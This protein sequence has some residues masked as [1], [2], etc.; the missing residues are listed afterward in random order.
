MIY[1]G[2][3]RGF[4]T[5]KY[6]PTITRKLNTKL[7]PV[8]VAVLT[9]AQLI[10][11]YRGWLV[12]LVGLALLWLISYGWTGSLMRCLTLQREMRFGWAQVGDR[13]EERFT[14]T[15][16]GLAPALWL[17]LRDQSTMP[18]YHSSRVTW[19]YGNSQNRWQT[20]IMCQHR[21]VF[22]LGPTQLQTGDPFGIY[23]L[24]LFF[25]ESKTI[26]I[27]PPIVP[28]PAI[29]I[30]PGGRTG[31][32]RP[33]ANSLDRTVSVSGLRDYVPGDDI[34]SIHWP[35]SAR[36]NALYVRLFDNL[37]AG[38]WWIFLDLAEAAQVGQG[39][40]ST[41]EH[42]VVLAASMADRG[43][44]AGEA[45]GLVSQGEQLTWLSPFGGDLQRSKI[46]Q[47]LALVKPGQRSLAELLKR[48]RPAFGRIAS[49]IIITPAVDGQWV[50]PLLPLLRRGA[51]AT[52]LLFDPLSYGGTDNPESTYLLLTNLGI[53]CHIIQQTLLERTGLTLKNQADW[54]W[55]ITPGGRAIPITPT[56]DMSWRQLS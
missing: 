21:G 51:E 13:L 4:D 41:E 48:A 12:L 36:R 25:P 38:D 6:P 53:T 23:T 18:N 7:L 49:I 30:V 37:P 47:A 9:L 29:T 1:Y 17:A 43:I 45:V 44:Q 24:S 8:L 50:E 22:T 15:N 26:T 20:R 42:G 16:S 56:R 14:V 31:E 39:Y 54:A 28:L 34:K 10:V 3:K 2:Q 35:T 32:G 52:V 33:Q 27:T 55:R 11:P 19:V 5:M 40:A 46:L